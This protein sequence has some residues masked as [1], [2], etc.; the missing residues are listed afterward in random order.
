MKMMTE[1][2]TFQQ[3]YYLSF[4]HKKRKNMPWLATSVRRKRFMEAG[5]K[6]NSE[7]FHH[8]STNLK[9]GIKIS[10]GKDLFLLVNPSIYVD[11]HLNTHKTGL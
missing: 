10:N 8:V 9:K 7:T 6:G 5:V 11:R 3:V 4:K 1:N 2:A